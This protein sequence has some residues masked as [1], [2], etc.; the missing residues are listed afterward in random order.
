MAL[1]VYSSAIYNPETGKTLVGIKESDERETVLFNAYLDGDHTND[2]ETELI[3]LAL[4]WFTVRYVKQFSD[5]L[6]NEKL[7]EVNR[8]IVEVQAKYA[9]LAEQMTQEEIKRQKQFEEQ[10]AEMT[11]MAVEFTNLVSSFQLEEEEETQEVE[12]ETVD[13]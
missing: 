5:Q 7:D 12:D 4:E 3:Q 11:L 9:E 8:V 6:L 10:K 13:G 2:S 1:R